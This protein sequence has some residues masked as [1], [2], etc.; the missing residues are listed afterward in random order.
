MVQ[1][2]FVTRLK[3]ALS[4]KRVTTNWMNLKENYLA[5]VPKVRKGP[6]LI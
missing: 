6:Y 5:K 2:Q 1:R 3:T 4:K